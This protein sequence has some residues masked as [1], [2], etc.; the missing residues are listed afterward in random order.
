MLIHKWSYGLYGT[1][2]RELTLQNACLMPLSCMATSGPITAKLGTKMGE[3]LFHW[4]TSN[5]ICVVERQL[6]YPP[7]RFWEKT[8]L[9]I[10]NLYGSI[11]VPASA[12][13]L[14]LEIA[15][16]SSALLHLPSSRCDPLEKKI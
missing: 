4:R 2:V 10:T 12:S 16:G 7:P 14:D 6:N 8:K 11:A 3:T 15:I 13:R 9:K 1:Y 5:V